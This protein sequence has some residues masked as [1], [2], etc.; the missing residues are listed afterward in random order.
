MASLGDYI[1]VLM[2]EKLN[3]GLA[4]GRKRALD[5]GKIEAS[6]EIIPGLA[7]RRRMYALKMTFIEYKFSWYS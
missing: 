7:P 6:A 2:N 4:G 1:S 5:E 3:V